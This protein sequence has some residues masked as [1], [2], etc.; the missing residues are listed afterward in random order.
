MTSYPKWA[1]LYVIHLKKVRGIIIK[2]KD[3]KNDNYDNNDNSNKWSCN[4]NFRR[5]KI[6]RPLSLGY[7]LKSSF[8]FYDRH[9]SRF[10]N[11]EVDCQHLG[12]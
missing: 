12:K 10:K 6:M 9:Y 3:D 5:A 4:D 11:Q 7:V 2:N 8:P 1:Y